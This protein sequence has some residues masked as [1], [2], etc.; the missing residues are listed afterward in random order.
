MRADS[1]RRDEQPGWCYCA[2][3]SWRLPAAL[4]RSVP[5]RLHVCLVCRRIHQAVRLTR[6]RDLDLNEPAAAKGIRIDLHGRAQPVWRLQL[7][8][9]Q[10]TANGNNASGQVIQQQRPLT[11]AGSFTSS[12]LAAMTSPLTGA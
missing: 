4:A 12:S 11:F 6:I 2:P 1:V 8:A 9:Q 7:Q 5:A 10:L 3:I